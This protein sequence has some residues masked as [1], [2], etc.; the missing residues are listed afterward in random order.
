MSPQL[1]EWDY[2][3]YNGH[4]VEEVERLKLLHI[5]QP[6][7]EGESLEE[8]VGRVLAFLDEK[9]LYEKV[10]IIPHR[11]AYYALEHRFKKLP[12]ASILSAPWAW[13]EGWAYAFEK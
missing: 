12:L 9:L 11:S 5:Q 7:L 3:A 10:M 8:A 4:P 1:R 6:F 2:G 13:R